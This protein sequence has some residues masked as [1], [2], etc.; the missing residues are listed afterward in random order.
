MTDATGRVG[1]NTGMRY[2]EIITEARAI[3]LDPETLP[4]V[5]ERT[6]VWANPRNVEV[7]DALQRHSLR[8]W[9][10]PDRF[11]IW[12]A[13][14]GIHLSIMQALI[15]VGEVPRDKRDD[16]IRCMLVLPD[17]DFSDFDYGVIDETNSV[18]VN[19]VS[20][21]VDYPEALGYPSV[22]KALGINL[23]K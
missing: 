2:S 20:L 17:G 18:I 3:I 10:T 9:A 13:N 14:E 23:P 7:R 19:G 22:E 1:L 11:Y 6:R 8:G 16:F 21:L 12:D 4:S 5:R 15:D